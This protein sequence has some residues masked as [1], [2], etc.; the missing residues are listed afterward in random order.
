[1]ISL[2]EEYEKKH[3]TIR[4]VSGS[5]WVYETLV[6]YARHYGKNDY[7]LVREALVEK[8]QR[9]RDSGKVDLNAPV[10]EREGTGLHWA[11][12]RSFT[13]TAPPWVVLW[14]EAYASHTGKRMMD[15]VRESATEKAQLVQG[16]LDEQ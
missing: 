2:S 16:E 5:D 8:A 10:R 6:N 15:V 13:T 7:Q 1:M 12:E 9:I 14:L 3:W 4:R 11:I